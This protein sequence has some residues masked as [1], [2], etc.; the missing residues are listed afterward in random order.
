[1]KAACSITGLLLTAAL[2]AGPPD[3][4]VPPSRSNRLPHSPLFLDVF[5][6]QGEPIVVEP[7][8]LDSAVRERGSLYR[9]KSDERLPGLLLIADG[10]TPEFFAQT[11]RE[12]AGIGYAVLI[13]PAVKADGVAARIERTTALVRKAA[14]RLKHRKDIFAEKIG[15]LGWGPTAIC[16]LNAAL[17]ESSQAAVLVDL[18]PP[19]A[20][21]DRIAAASQRVAVLIIRADIR[22]RDRLRQRLA[23]MPV[24]L[25]EFRLGGAKPGFMDCRSGEAF[26]GKAADR[27]WFEI[28]EFLGK[29]VEDAGPKPPLT[30][31][32]T[33]SDQSRLQFASIADAMR[34]ANGPRGARTA[35]ARA[36][37]EGPR[38]D[39]DWKRLREQSRLLS[40]CG[41]WL[42]DQTP[43]K[44]STSSW[45]RHAVAYRD[46]AQALVGAAERSDRNAAQSALS[47]LNSSCA[48][49][50]AEHR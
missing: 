39:R 35:V 45:R 50:H 17:A 22:A 29:Y 13:I 43:R 18:E 20:I 28:Y 4:A 6:T 30:V 49:C 7:F 2:F 9:P 21:D 8:A 12:L 19:T 25:H 3:A 40:D 23:K 5:R 41:Q 16:A 34:K 1:L 44:G 42:L 32:T 15:V 11:A 36:L 24:E 47:R 26:D 27:A 46:A 37:N 10:A 14:R 31:R 48:R 33:P 38:D